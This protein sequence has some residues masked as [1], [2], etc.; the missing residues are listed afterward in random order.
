L[1]FARR[2]V[3]EAGAARANYNSNVLCSNALSSAG[4]DEAGERFIVEVQIYRIY[5]LF[6]LA[7]HDPINK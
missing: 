7:F 2:P 3:P 5:L 6:W 1:E 4:E